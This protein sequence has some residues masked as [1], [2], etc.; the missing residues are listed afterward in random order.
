MTENAR[1]TPYVMFGTGPIPGHVRFDTSDEK[2][3]VVSRSLKKNNGEIHAERAGSVRT[4][5]FLR[6][7]L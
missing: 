5:S 6:A 7:L 4:V 2:R 3:H 1:E